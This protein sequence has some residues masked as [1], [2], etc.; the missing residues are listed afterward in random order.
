MRY[1]RSSKMAILV[2]TFIHQNDVVSVETRSLLAV[3]SQIFG[4]Q[5]IPHLR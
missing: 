3:L 5:G 1:V 2:K 4:C